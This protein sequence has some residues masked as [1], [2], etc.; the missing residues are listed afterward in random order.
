MAGPSDLQALAQETL[1][2]SIDAL[3]T[4]PLLSPGLGGAP[5][6][7]FISPGTPADDCCEQLSVQVAA[8]TTSPIAQP[9]IQQGHL[10][11]GY[12]DSLVALNIR[13]TRCM[14]GWEANAV[15]DTTPS[16]DDLTEKAAQVNADGWALWTHLFNLVVAGQLFTICDEVWWDGMRSYGPSGGCVGWVL[17]IRAQLDGYQEVVSS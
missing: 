3:D 16:A 9:G 11:S 4:I 7:T 17:T 8:V 5:A 14:P 6:R 2:A 10:Q 15:N 1:D 12:R 13:I